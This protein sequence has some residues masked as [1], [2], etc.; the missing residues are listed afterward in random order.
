M[1]IDYRIDLDCIPKAEMTTEGIVERLKARARIDEVQ[2]FYTLHGEGDRTP[3]QM[4]F[5]YT[6][7]TPQGE[8]TVTIVLSDLIE[9]AAELD[10]YAHH[11]I[12]CPANRTGRA[13]GCT[14][15]ISYPI[16]SAGEKWLLDRL[17]GIDEPLVWLLLKQGV[18]E[19]GYDGAT[20]APL[21]IN[22][23][24]FE[25]RGVRGR[26]MVEFLIT[27]NQVFEMLFLVGSISPAHAGVL[28][29][30]FG[31]IGRADLEASGIVGVMSR[32][33]HEGDPAWPDGGASLP[34]AARSAALAERFPL[35]GDA[36]VPDPE[37]GRVEPTTAQFDAFLGAL[38]RA[39]VLG[40]PLW[41]DV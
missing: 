40:V 1:A 20:V 23:T 35:A 31:A 19:L 4:G 18:L 34:D 38:Y 3:D 26:D 29:L 12:G 21:R 9:R 11:C 36:P 39:W 37:T 8:E 7:T 41:L 28:L 32:K 33:P 30:F 2:A 14:G 24:Y 25:S 5:D 16:A 13:Y 10:R 6:R 27:S 22:P 17:P 15:Q